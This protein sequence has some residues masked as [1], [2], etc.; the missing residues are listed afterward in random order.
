MVLSRSIYNRL[1]KNGKSFIHFVGQ[2]E[3]GAYNMC[4]NQNIK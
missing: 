3:R 2:S 4:H 1:A